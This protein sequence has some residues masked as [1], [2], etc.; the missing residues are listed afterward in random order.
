[1][2]ALLTDYQEFRLCRA[3]GWTPEQLAAQPATL[4]QRWIAYLNAE[5]AAERDATPR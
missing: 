4:V 1:L 2:Q 3:L 5:A